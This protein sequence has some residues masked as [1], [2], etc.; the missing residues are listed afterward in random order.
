MSRDFFFKI[1]FPRSSTTFSDFIS[2]ESKTKSIQRVILQLY[3][4]YIHYNHMHMLKVHKIKVAIGR[5]LS[6]EN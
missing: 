5:S 1:K 3:I 2:T 4:A 6:E